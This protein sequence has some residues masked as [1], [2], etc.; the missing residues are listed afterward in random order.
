M[1]QV[2]SLREVLERGA[3]HNDGAPQSVSWLTLP[4]ANPWPL[5]QPPLLG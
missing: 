3:W 1:D 2:R 4:S 5:G